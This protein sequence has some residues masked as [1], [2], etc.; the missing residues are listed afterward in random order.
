VHTLG[1]VGERGL[2]LPIC[3]SHFSSSVHIFVFLLTCEELCTFPVYPLYI[4]VSPA[5][6]DLPGGPG[7]IPGQAPGFTMGVC[8]TG[9]DLPWTSWLLLMRPGNPKYFHASGTPLNCW[10]KTFSF[11]RWIDLPTGLPKTFDGGGVASPSSGGPKCLSRRSFSLWLP[12][13]SPDVPKRA[14]SPEARPPEIPLGCDPAG[15][16][17]LLLPRGRGAPRALKVGDAGVP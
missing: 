3:R 12:A 4:W 8:G 17:Q 16:S 7:D 10:H 6:R 11:G 1:S 13:S 5:N 15:L 9:A 14:L 2:S